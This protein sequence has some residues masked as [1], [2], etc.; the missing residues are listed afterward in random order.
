MA[1]NFVPFD[2]TKPMSNTK[3]PKKESGVKQT[4]EV[5]SVDNQRHVQSDYEKPEHGKDKKDNNDNKGNKEQV[6]KQK[7]QQSSDTSA[8]EKPNELQGSTLDQVASKPNRRKRKSSKQAQQQ[9]DFG[10]YTYH[11][12]DDHHIV[13]EDLEEPEHK[14]D[15]KV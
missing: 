5:K 11:P 1:I 15:V 8:K 7:Q 13:E 3:A 14:V 2:S 9:D 4:P 6:A 10:L 12:Q